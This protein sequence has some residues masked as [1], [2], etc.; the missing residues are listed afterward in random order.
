MSK[1]LQQLQVEEFLTHIQNRKL[2]KLMLMIHILMKAITL[3]LII[4]HLEIEEQRLQQLFKS[5]RISSKEIVINLLATSNLI[6]I[7]QVSQK[8]LILIIFQAK[9]IKRLMILIM[10]LIIKNQVR[11]RCK[12]ILF[13]GVMNQVQQIKNRNK[14]VATLI[15]ILILE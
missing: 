15:L 13:H 3:N 10:Y 6:L 9:L 11:Q 12:M 5:K 4:S 7:K 14:Q 8:N 1:G 2:L